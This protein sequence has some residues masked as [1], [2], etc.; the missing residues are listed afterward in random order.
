[1]KL[2]VC[3]L[4]DDVIS[5]RSRKRSCQ[6]KASSGKYLSDK[7]TAEF[8]GPCLLLGFANNS[9]GHAVRE[10][11]NTGDNGLLPMGFGPYG[12][13]LKGRDFTAFVIPASAK[14]AIRKGV[15]PSMPELLKMK[16]QRT[17]KD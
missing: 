6:C 15:L 2:L 9:Y 7:L 17:A 12:G 5:L 1:M 8:T 4:C 10:Q 14:T 13:E 11:V 16:A 3:L